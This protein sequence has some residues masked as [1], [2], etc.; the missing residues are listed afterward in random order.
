VKISIWLV[1]FV[2]SAIVPFPSEAA[3]LRGSPQKAEIQ[4]QWADRAGVR[5]IQ[6][7]KELAA[8]KKSGQLV[9]LPTGPGV[10]VDDR[11]ATELRFCRPEVNKFLAALGQAFS[12]VFAD[13]FRVTSAVRTVTYQKTLRKHNPNAA[14]T[15]GPKASS[16]LRGTTIDITKVGLTEEQ[17]KWLKQSLSAKATKGKIIVVEE[18]GQSVFHVMVKPAAT[19]TRET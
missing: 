3:T 2:L 18:F 15:I 19:R 6:S 17:V 8:L 4:N 12:T 14:A 7:N 5:P 9:P 16:H 11:L 10:V 1:L 13:S